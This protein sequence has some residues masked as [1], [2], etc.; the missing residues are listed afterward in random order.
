DEKKKIVLGTSAEPQDTH[1]SRRAFTPTALVV[2]LTIFGANGLCWSRRTF[3]P[4]ALIKYVKPDEQH[5]LAD[6]VLS[7]TACTYFILIYTVQM[8][9]IAFN[10]YV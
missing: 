1:A 7:A 2:F 4:S 10:L 3:A 9:T 8:G 6:K 5:T